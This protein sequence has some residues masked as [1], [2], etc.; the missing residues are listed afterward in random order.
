MVAGQQVAIRGKGLRRDLRKDGRP[1][2]LVR[3]RSRRA[4]DEVVLNAVMDAKIAD[5]DS[6]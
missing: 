3:R 2:S 1:G 4:A 5:P 6:L